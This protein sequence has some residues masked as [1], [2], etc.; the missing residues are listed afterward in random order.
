MNHRKY[1]WHFKLKI[2]LL[3]IE[4]CRV[5]DFYFNK[6]ENNNLNFLLFIFLKL[7]VAKYLK[8]IKPHATELS[9]IVQCYFFKF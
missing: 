7:I 6:K 4:K 8:Y 1:F 5:I 2:V 9:G 3:N